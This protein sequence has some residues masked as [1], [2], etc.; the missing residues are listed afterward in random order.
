MQN[1]PEN[2]YEA[3]YKWFTESRA[4]NDNS[5]IIPSSIENFKGY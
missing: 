2:A 3:G 4:I 5:M 1:T